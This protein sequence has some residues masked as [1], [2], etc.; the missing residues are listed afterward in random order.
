MGLLKGTNGLPRPIEAQL[1]RLHVATP[2]RLSHD[3]SD[4]VIGQQMHPDLFAH[5]VRSLG[6]KHLHSHRGLERSYIQFCVPSLSEQISQCRCWIFRRIQE[7]RYDHDFAGPL[8]AILDPDTDLAE[9]QFLGHRGVL[10]GAHP[11]RTLGLRPSDDV[12]IRAQPTSP[13]E[14]GLASLVQPEDNV[15]TS[16]L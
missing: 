6:P 12:I 16:G 10:G 5:H 2:G 9:F 13:A 1:A 15:D 4:Q 3:A 7:R 11:V 14:V 8:L